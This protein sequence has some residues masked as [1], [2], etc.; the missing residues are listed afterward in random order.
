[1]NENRPTPDMNYENYSVED[2]AA[3]KDFVQWVKNSSPQQAQHWATWLNDHPHKR[4]V[5][6]EARAL[7]QEIDF[8]MAPEAHA[9][10]QDV[11]E[12]IKAS[13]A[14]TVDRPPVPA[15][16]RELPRRTYSSVRWLRR[17]GIV[18][19]LVLVIAIPAYIFLHGPVV[20]ETQYGETSQIELPDGSLVVLNANSRLEL[21]DDWDSDR[22]VW[23]RGEAYFE[24]R[25]KTNP[26]DVSRRYK[27][28][29]HTSSLDVNVVGTEFTVSQRDKTTVVL[30]EGRI[31]LAVDDQYIAMKPGDKV[32][33]SGSKELRHET[34]N[35][36]V[37]SAWKDHVWILDGLT[38][39]EIAVRIRE[40]Y[41]LQ[42]EIKNQ[43]LAD[44]EITG[45]V[46]TNNLE[47]LLSALSTVF[48]RKFI[49]RRDRILIE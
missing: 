20:Y 30:N 32:E 2:F 5:V 36:K 29:V 46:P 31:E 40:T 48:D 41:G 37:Y 3:D 49:R 9:M 13:N 23:L 44:V 34:V 6:E 28:T 7:V 22:E 18:S 27:F 1:M 47:T 15:P 11:W 17:A 39:E 10:A 35:P 21:S 14:Q 43:P 33:V 12:R 16:A 42:V 8:N 26:A 45:V 25:K 38:L 4:Q 19:A 24:V